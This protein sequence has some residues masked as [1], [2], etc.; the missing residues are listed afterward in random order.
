MMRRRLLLATPLLLAGCGLSERPYAERRQWPLMARRPRP[1]RA[2]PGAPVLLV[3]ALRAGPGLD[4]RGLQSLQADGSI[5]SEFYE[6][7]AA[8]P[9]QGA[10]EALRLWLADSGL[11]SAVIASGSRLEPDQ[12]LEGELTGLWTIPATGQAHCALGITVVAERATTRR[13]LLQQRLAAEAP[14]SGNSPREAVEAQ[15]AALAAVLS[16]IEAALRK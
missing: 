14:L 15:S 11:F 1:E 3:R 4:T 12:V 6:E 8:P 9:V 16:Q 5:R 7:W 13:V 2:R 10:E